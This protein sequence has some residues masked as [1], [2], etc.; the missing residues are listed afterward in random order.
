MGL[1]QALSG[2]RGGVNNLPGGGGGPPPVGVGGGGVMMGIVKE[3]PL[4]I[5]EQLA[6]LTEK[7]TV[8][9]NDLR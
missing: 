2:G 6:A 5:M 7:T 9:A 8:S 4:D 1:L 3:L